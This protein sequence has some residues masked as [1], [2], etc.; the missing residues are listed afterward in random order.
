MIV[1]QNVHTWLHRPPPAGA[2]LWV[3][4]FERV[5]AQ[6]TVYARRVPSHFNIGFVLRGG[7]HVRVD[8]VEHNLSRESVFLLWPGCPYHVH[9]RSPTARFFRL[10]LR[11]TR[12]RAFVQALGLQPASCAITPER[13]RDA[14]AALTQA[15]QLYQTRAD[16]HRILALLYGF[17]SHCRRAPGSARQQD[18]GEDLADGALN[19]ME[20]DYPA[21]LTIAGLARDLG[22]SP[23]TLLRAFKRFHGETPLAALTRIRLL[24]ARDLLCSTDLKIAAVAHAVGYSNEKYFYR[25][26]R[27]GM[28]ET[29]AAHRRANRRYPASRSPAGEAAPS[30]TIPAAARS[31]RNRPG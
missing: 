28:G 29:P 31:S 26:F 17:A 30:P 3:D 14:R 16:A 8:T 13:P 24:A 11:G 21:P 12:I 7:L 25:C 2:N 10:R 9:T 6:G 22:T 4:R 1:Q 19:I 18:R 15:F 20:A 23:A 5:D 27:K